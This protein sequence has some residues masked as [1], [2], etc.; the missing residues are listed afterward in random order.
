M[1]YDLVFEGGG[2]KGM[3]FVGALREL[4]RR[5]HTFG[6]FLG[7]SAGAIMATFAAAGLSTAEMLDAPSF[8]KVNPADFPIYYMRLS[9]ATLPVSTLSD[10]AETVLQQQVSTIRGVAQVQFWG[11]QKYAVRVQI[12]PRRLAMK[13]LGFEDVERAV[14]GGNSNL[15]TGSLSGPDKELSTK[16]TGNLASANGYNDIV[17]AHR[18]GAPVRI[19][20][21]GR[22]IDGVEQV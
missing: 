17:I 1:Q 15:P 5:G 18:N 7:T 20:D 8:R 16:T 12:D 10:Y 13:N 22:A 2:A 19:Q 6:R 4:E 21:V 3:V 9:S 14:R 11:Q